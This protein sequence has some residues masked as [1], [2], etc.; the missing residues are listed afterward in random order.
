MSISKNCSNGVVLIIDTSLSTETKVAVNE[1]CHKAALRWFVI[2]PFPKVIPYQMLL[3]LK[4]L[5][6][7]KKSS[8][9]LAFIGQYTKFNNKWDIKIHGDIN[10]LKCHYN[11]L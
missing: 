8:K 2:V 10:T 11:E 5:Y 9:G 4:R 6:T 7:D 1:M 3:L